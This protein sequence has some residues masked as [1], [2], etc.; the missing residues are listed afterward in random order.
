MKFDQTT[1][2]SV[3]PLVSSLLEQETFETKNWKIDQVKFVEYSL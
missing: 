3:L 1:L 2:V